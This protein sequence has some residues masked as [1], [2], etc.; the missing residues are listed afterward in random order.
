[1][2]PRQCAQPPSSPS[3]TPASTAHG[4]MCSRST[5]MRTATAT[6]AKEEGSFVDTA[7]GKDKAE[8]L[9]MTLKDSEQ[10]AGKIVQGAGQL[11]ARCRNRE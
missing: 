5:D 1:M 10:L 8:K 7:I 2:A 4:R 9:K 3:A 11:A 6:A